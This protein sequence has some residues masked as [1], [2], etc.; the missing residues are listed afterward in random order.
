MKTI[1]VYDS[2]NYF[3]RFIKYHLKEYIVQKEKK[4]NT[5]NIDF[6]NASDYI[7]I[8]I[9]NEFDVFAFLFFYRL[10]K[11]IIICS[12]NHSILSYYDDMENVFCFDISLPKAQI[13]NNIKDI[14]Y[15]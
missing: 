2:K 1:L 6:Y 13:F 15:E 12:E 9:Y 14:F 8:V 5:K 4:V 3:F 10:N 11:R 7:F